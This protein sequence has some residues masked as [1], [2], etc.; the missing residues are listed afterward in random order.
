MDVD[1]AYLC[2]LLLPLLRHCVVEA[3]ALSSRQ[4]YPSRSSHK[5]YLDEALNQHIQNLGEL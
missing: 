1:L 4:P 2:E 5:S 3:V